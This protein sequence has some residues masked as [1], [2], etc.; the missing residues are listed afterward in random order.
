MVFETVKK[1]IGILREGRKKK[2][3]LRRQKEYEKREREYQKLQA[4][5]SALK[6]EYEKRKMYED[7]RRKV[8]EERR[9]IKELKSSK[10]SIKRRFLADIEKGGS[11]AY[12]QLKSRKRFSTKLYG[13][14]RSVGK[15]SHRGRRKIS[16]KMASYEYYQYL[17]L[18][19]KFGR[20]KESG[21][22]S[23]LRRMS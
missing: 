14:K 6:S 13:K 8:E 17:K 23:R 5:E 7:Q 22:K 20:M 9:K 19:K 3:E 16:N 1:D 21:R 15:R 18:K 10:P 4:E 11:F 2:M 12:K